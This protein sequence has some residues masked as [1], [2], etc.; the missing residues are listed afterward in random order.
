MS[1]QLG[2][3]LVA[4]PA[5]KSEF[6]C[7]SVVLLYEATDTAV[8]GI[9]LNKPSGKT[10]RDLAQ[11]QGLTTLSKEPIYIGG[12]AHPS[13]LVMLHTGDWRCSNTQQIGDD[14][15]ISSDRSMNARL[16]RGDTPR[17]WRL[18]MGLTAWT[19]Q[20][21]QAELLDPRVGWLTVPFQHQDLWREPGRE[22]WRWCL[23]RATQEL[24]NTYF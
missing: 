3:L 12:P 5:L 14:L 16:C 18:F 19:P 8:M 13:S 15:F 21:L 7:Q 6:W 24:V 4:P 2:D 10:L 22:Q 23:D 17:S 9:T 20:Q 11:H 1:R